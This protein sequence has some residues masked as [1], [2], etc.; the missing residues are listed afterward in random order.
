VGVIGHET[1]VKRQC[2][3]VGSEMIGKRLQPALEEAAVELGLELK[4]HNS[5]NN[6][7]KKAAAAAAVEHVA[8][9]DAVGRDKQV[10]CH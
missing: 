5:S 3:K 1:Q 2:F 9:V 10:E 7:K 6:L 8:W 4:R